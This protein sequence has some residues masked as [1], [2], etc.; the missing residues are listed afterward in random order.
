[1]SDLTK[2]EAE[3]TTIRNDTGIIAF[4]LREISVSL[5]MIAT[6]LH[7]IVTQTGPQYQE[8]MDITERS[9]KNLRDEAAKEV[10]K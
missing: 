2:L 10:L 6:T 1:M 5:R 7:T 9:Y 4:H 3:I 8:T